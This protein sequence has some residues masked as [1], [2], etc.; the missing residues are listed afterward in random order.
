M[1]PAQARLRRRPEFTAVVRSGR[2]AGR[3]TMVLHYLPERPEQPAGDSSSPVAARAGF[4]VGKSVGNSVIRHRVTRRL[5]AVVRSE[6]D[7]LPAGA[8]LVVRARPDAA[9]ADSAALHRDLSAGLDR[10]LGD[11]GRVR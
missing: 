2:R 11:R 6:L 10:L 4:V 1:L 9:A 8:D 7:R 3:P 5:R